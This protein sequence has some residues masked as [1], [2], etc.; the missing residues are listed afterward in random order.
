[1]RPRRRSSPGLALRRNPAAPAEAPLHLDGEALTLV[2]LARDGF[3]LAPGDY[4]ETGHGLTIPDMP[5]ECVLEIETRISPKDNTDFTGLYVS[6]GNY[7]TQCEAQGFR[8]ITFFPDRPDV[9]SRYT[10]TITS[11]LPGDA[12]ERQS[13]AGERSRRRPALGH[14]DRSASKTLLSVR[15]GGRRSRFGQ[16]QFCHAVRPES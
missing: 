4:H 1:M 13:R 2:R 14:L 7:F 8:R 12:V 11:F 3:P 10:T 9:M 5:D 16:G 6:G 15:S